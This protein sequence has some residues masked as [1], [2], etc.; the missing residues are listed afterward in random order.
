MP[1]ETD[2]S[3]SPYFDDFDE[4]KDFYKI[5]FRPGVSVQT[6]ELNQ[7]QT[8]LQTQIERFGDNIFKRGTIID[9]CNFL[10]YSSYPYIK[11]NDIQKDGLTADPSSYVGYFARSVDTEI[12]VV[13]Y[14]T[15]YQ[16]GF[17]ATTPDLKTLYLNYINSGNS[18]TTNTFSAGEVV[19]IYDQRYPI[20]SAKVNNGGISFSNSDTI[21]VTSALV[22]NVS[23][24]TFTNG[25]YL[26]QT[27]TGANV[28][29]YGIDTTTLASSNQVILFVRPRTLDLTNAVANAS[30]WTIA[31]AESV[32]NASATVTATVES[33]IGS[34]AE[35]QLLTDSSGK[36]IDV[37]I[38]SRGIGYSSLP[39]ITVKSPD[40][41]TGLSTLSITAQ[42]Y[43]ANVQIST[44]SNPVG[45]GYAFGVTEG[46]IYQKGYFSRVSPQTIIVEKYNQYP[47]SVVVGFDT[48]EE[49]IDSNID[50]TLLDN[51]IG[52]ENVNAPGANRLKL[53]PELVVLTTE[54]AAANDSFFVISEWSEGRPFR[55]NRTTAYNKITDELARRSHEESGNYSIDKFRVTTR[56]PSNTAI[57]GNTF[58]IVVDPGLAY[59][60][61]YRVES[62]AN[63]II[64]SPKGNDVLTT[65]NQLVSLDFENFVRIKEVGG[66]FQFSTGDEIK[67]YDTAKTFI[68]N[69][70]AATTGNT[71][72]VGS[73][74]GTANMRS[75]TYFDGTPGTAN[76]T[77]KLY[78]YNVNMNTGK[79]FRDVKSVYY[80]GTNKG[81][82]DLVLTLDGTLNTNIATMEGIGKDSLIFPSGVYSLKSSS[83][84][85]YTYRTIDQTLTV[86]NNTGRI[87]KDISS[88]VGEYFPY[89]TNLTDSE[90]KQIYLI[91]TSN[92]LT[93]FAAETGTVSVLST[94]PNV[95]G[96]STT[97]LNSF[98]VG[99]YVKI[100]NGSSNSIN[101][102]TSIVNNTLLILSSNCSFTQSV[103][104][105]VY[106]CFPKNVPISLGSR[107]VGQN[108]HSA[109]VSS[110][111]N[112]L[113]VQFKYANGTNMSFD[114]S[115]AVAADASMAVN[116]ERRNVTSL[117]KTANRK[118]FVKIRVANNVAN[119]IGPWCLGVP[120]A[121]RLRAVYVGNSSVDNTYPNSV[122]EFYIDHNQTS[123]FYDLS[124]LYKKPSS[125]IRVDSQDYF[126]VEF[127]YG[128]STSG[129]FF[130][131]VSYTGEANS[132]IVANNDSLPLSSLTTEYNTFEIPEVH[133][134]KGEYFDLIN[135]FDFRP[136]VSNTAS[137]N[138]TYSDAPI[139]PPYTISFGATSDPANDKKFPLPQSLFKCEIDQYLGRV[140][141]VFVDREA[142]IFTIKGTPTTILD[143]SY[144]PET[145]KYSMRLNNLVIK[146][147]PNVSKNSSNVFSEILNRRIANERYLNTR[148]KDRIIETPLTERDVE[149]EQP[150]GFTMADIGNIAR[151]VTDLEYYVSLSLL[152]TNMKDRV[153]PSSLDPTL[154]RFKYG[155]FVDDFSTNKFSDRD[156][157][158][159]SATIEHD[160]IL[161]EREIFTI[162]FPAK[163]VSCD[164][165]DHLIISQDNATIEPPPPPPPPTANTGGPTVPTPPP[166]T[167]P[168]VTGVSNN[169][170][171][172]KESSNRG[173]LFGREE[174]DFV[175]VTMATVA[176]PVTLYG[177]FYGGADHISVFQGNTLIWSSGAPI[178]STVDAL[179]LTEAD[180]TKL[181]SNVVP[182]G[183]FSGITFQNFSL[184]ADPRGQG[185]RNS[186]KVS[187]THNPSN[188]LDYTIKTTKYSIVW[189]YALEYPINSNT[190]S[191]NT[192]SNTTPQPVIYNGT[193]VVTPDK[194]D[195]TYF[196][197]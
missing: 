167:P 8:I 42:N 94:S 29:I 70:V 149:K 41:S 129:G 25:E 101:R 50:P 174:V 179:N 72:P 63:F 5:L 195:I 80:N 67:L 169:W 47:N 30:S 183:W 185:I 191:S 98:Q 108:G 88:V 74:I 161:P 178:L 180:K 126:L 61:G 109:N 97:F 96:T 21:V 65:N 28:Q 181:K 66:N 175:N 17:E 125:S 132:E 87:V 82:A 140:D 131:T 71:N 144:A 92:A 156:N 152:E 184:A 124:F 89:G 10:Y 20:F 193:M 4:K 1:L 13:A 57:E 99:D 6:R 147:Y 153:I 154:N 123:S 118:K 23:T 3:V 111:G 44:L 143:E 15:N 55:Q 104:T 197:T 16:D 102:I 137:P 95:T 31:N 49:I 182:S 120:D 160:D 177:H 146:P 68:T 37:T 107:T 130:N 90:L 157:P 165:I 77:Y 119:T 151:R 7:L 19:T 112:I 128:T 76:A 84:N 155:F 73:I 64:N 105:Y 117:T 166:V 38:T 187:W 168:V 141:S 142:N 12:D 115:T 34:G 60:E 127:D 171:V 189:R 134:N 192:A 78:L 113:T 176:A 81:I 18:G 103:T 158:Q 139:N 162:K 39:N 33:I 135:T 121:F 22:V 40:N 26:Y 145:P 188:G 150:T 86:A 62:K 32:R 163:K 14:I 85:T 48:R 27:S 56:S 106:R 53:I 164:Y 69:S 91:P 110:A 45:N 43:L 196:N 36:I 9:G 133:T 122:S 116:I 52:T 194:I 51:V 59:I 2:L 100:S 159:Y 186:F 35:G 54:A 58:S 24:G 172:R 11:I 136:S 148:I 46:I 170:I 114:T 173:S 190:V 93:A 79:N 138:T 83:N 75:L